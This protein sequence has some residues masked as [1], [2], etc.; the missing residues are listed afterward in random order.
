MS[1]PRLQL[2]LDVTDM[3]LAV[4]IARELQPWWDILEVGTALLLKE[5][6][7]S[8]T[9]MRKKF[10]D[11]VILA[12]TKIMDS[13]KLLAEIAC[14]AG[15]DMISVISAASA[16]TIKSCITVA[17]S[18]GCRVLLDHLSDEWQGE[19]LVEKIRFGADVIGF[20]LPK[21]MQEAAS[22]NLGAISEF[23]R[24]SGV[25]ISIAGGITPNR[26]SQTK[27]FPINIFVVGGYLINAENRKE[28]AQQ[29]KTTMLAK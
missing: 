14:E 29:I 11:A 21:D 28:K 9:E 19:A 12:D 27:G 2:A 7:K 6:L 4:Q 20:H 15:A 8:V 24:S 22:M 25:E 13:G 1:V 3:H 5:G 26:I 16:S 10:P 18:R 23:S 17:H